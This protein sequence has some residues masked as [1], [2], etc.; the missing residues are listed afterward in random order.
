MKES[1]GREQPGLGPRLL[2]RILQSSADQIT[3]HQR[4]ARETAGEAGASCLAERASR[5]SSNGS[6]KHK[7]DGEAGASCFARRLSRNSP[8]VNTSNKPNPSI[9]LAPLY[10]AK[11]SLIN[12]P[13]SEYSGG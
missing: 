7:P 12:T 2:P 6:P 3:I 10:P 8:T 4:D 11:N 13:A 5:D 1:A 9:P